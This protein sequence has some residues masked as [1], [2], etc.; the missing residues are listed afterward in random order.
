MTYLFRKDLQNRPLPVMNVARRDLM[1][2]LNES[3]LDPFTTVHPAFLKRMEDIHLNRYFSDIT[4]QL[5]DELAAYAQVDKD[6][7]LMG[8]GADDLLYGMFV[9]VRNTAEDFALAL[10]P[11]YFDYTTYCNAVGLGIKYVTLDEN[12][13]FDADAYLSLAAQESCRLVIL[14]H[15]NNPTGNLLDE[16]KIE[17]VLRTITDKPVLVDETYF[18]YSGRTYIPRLAEFPNLVII[19]SFSKAFSCAGLRFAYLVSQPQNIIEIRKTRMFFHSS[20]FIQALALTVLEHKE[21]F[22]E[23][24]RR[25]IEWREELLHELQNLPGIKVKPS[26]TNFLIFGCDPVSRELLDC[27]DTNQIAVRSVAH[28]PRLEGYLRVTV[29]YPADNQRFLNTVKAF[30]AGQKHNV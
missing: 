16:R 23:H 18:E 28:L 25:V 4:T 12:F 11:S 8:N 1:L 29:S 19:R 5:Q 21:I 7:L 10:S 24:N 6:C 13:D 14:C 27:L 15:P 2:C 30:L 26:S 20:I 3:P 17:R 9:S 22:L